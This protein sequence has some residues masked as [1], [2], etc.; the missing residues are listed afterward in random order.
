M[1]LW[2]RREEYTSMEIHRVPFLRQKSMLKPKN[3]V[4]SVNTPVKQAT[5]PLG[6]D[7]F[8]SSIRFKGKSD[9]CTSDDIEKDPIHQLNRAL[10]DKNKEAFKEKLALIQEEQI[11]LNEPGL[12][13]HL[14][15]RVAVCTQNKAAIKALYEAGARPNYR[16]EQGETPLIRA[17][18][19]QATNGPKALKIVNMLLAMKAD[20]DQMTKPDNVLLF[21]KLAPIH[22]AARQKDPAILAALIKAGAKV[23]IPGDYSQTALHEAADRANPK[24]VKMLLAAKADSGRVNDAGQTAL[25]IVL[26]NYSNPAYQQNKQDQL[27]TIELLVKYGH[28]LDVPRTSSTGKPIK[29]DPQVL[30]ASKAVLS[31]LQSTCVIL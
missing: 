24:S 8:E 21:E 14:P 9:Y 29:A 4:P 30:Q 18:T 19:G 17:V 6:Q 13:G 28:G 16:D 27:E 20:V 25:D 2:N 31:E 7:R 1:G 22:I 10:W 11:D 5:S 15:L 26:E 23:N 12:D 3:T